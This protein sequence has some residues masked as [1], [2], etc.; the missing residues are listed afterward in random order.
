MK[1]LTIP[2]P[3]Q[4]RQGIIYAKEHINEFDKIIAV[5][6]FVD[7][8]Q[9]K[10]KWISPLLN[11]KK[12]V[13]EWIDFK[14]EFPEKV[15][16]CI[17]NHDLAYLNDDY[18]I[19]GHQS[20]HH[21]E[22]KEVLMENLRYFVMGV[23][24]DGVVYSHAG[25]SKQFFEKIRTSLNDAVEP[26]S[27]ESFCN[28]LLWN[29]QFKWFDYC[30]D[31]YSGY[32]N[33]PCQGPLWIRPQSLAHTSLFPKQVVGHTEKPMLIDKYGSEILVCDSRGHDW[34]PVIID[35]DLKS[36]EVPK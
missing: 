29:K 10:E 25:F 20:I 33:D 5:G 12:I 2:D 19:S 7:D 34:F 14:T 15:T 26:W 22:I 32:G 8:W 13:K 31:D 28:D 24:V 23:T 21:D 11:P 27:F 6:D 16:V 36:V 35:G 17:G 3:H 18:D 9:S 30:H 1:V 4:S